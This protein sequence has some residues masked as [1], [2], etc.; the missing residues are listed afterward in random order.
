MPLTLPWEEMPDCF[1]S[2]D[3]RGPSTPGFYAYIQV[4]VHSCRLVGTRSSDAKNFR[5]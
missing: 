2:I 5:G 3:E 4:L 1:P